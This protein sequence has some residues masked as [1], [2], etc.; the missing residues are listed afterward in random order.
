MI[1]IS[2]EDDGIGFEEEVLEQFHTG[3]ELYFD[4]SDRPRIGLVNIRDRLNFSYPDTAEFTI[5]SEKNQYSRV[6]IAF[7]I[8]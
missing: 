5:E 1:V 3:A 2:V 4:G 6:R 7:P 8:K